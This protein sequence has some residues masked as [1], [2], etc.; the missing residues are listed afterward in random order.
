MDFIILGTGPGMPKAENHLS[1]LYVEQAGKRFLF[2]CGEG[3]SRQLLKHKLDGNILDAVFIS[4]FHPDHISGIYML[5]QMLYLQKRTRPLALFL[6]EQSEF[7]ERTLWFMYTFKEKFAFELGIY[8]C[9]DCGKMFP[10]VFA[11]PTDHLLG[12]HD[13][14]EERNLPNKMHSYSFRID[15]P[16]GALVYTADI[17]TT[18]VIADILENCHTAIVDA[19]HPEMEQILKL[20]DSDIGRIILTHGL[21]DNLAAYL[22]DRQDKRFEIAREDH[23]YHI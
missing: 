9:R 23:R 7:F 10:E 22:S 17:Q 6:P 15:S 19:Q 1:S 16:D 21:S 5:L 14:V 4:H 20:R 3:T 18:D 8:D 2:D 13:I 12:Y 11:K